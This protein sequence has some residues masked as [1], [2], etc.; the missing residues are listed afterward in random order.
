MAAPTPTST[1]SGLLTRPPPAVP[2]PRIAPPLDMG[3]PMDI[4]ATRKAKSLPDT[5]RRCGRPG[6]WAKA[7]DLRFDVRHMEIDEL[8]TFLEDM[9]AAKDAAPTE[10]AVVEADETPIRTDDVVPS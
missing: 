2:A 10:S 8:Q 7:C 3:V 6:H 4:D 9:L 1:R 5:C